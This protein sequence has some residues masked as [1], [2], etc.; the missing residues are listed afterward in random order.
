[1]TF[2]EYFDIFMFLFTFFFHLI[3]CK[4]HVDIDCTSDSNINYEDFI[5]EFRNENNF[6]SHLS[7]SNEG[8]EN[9]E[10]SKNE[11]DKILSTNQDSNESL[12]IEID[13][14]ISSPSTSNILDQSSKPSLSSTHNE[15][16]SSNP[17]LPFN[18]SSSESKDENLLFTEGQFYSKFNTPSPTDNQDCNSNFDN[19]SPIANQDSNSNYD[20]NNDTASQDSNSNSVN[21]EELKDHNLKLQSKLNE[22]H[23]HQQ[24]ADKLSKEMNNM[25]SKSNDD[26]SQ[27]VYQTKENVIQ[28]TE[29]TERAILNNL[30]VAK[31]LEGHENCPDCCDTHLEGFNNL[32]KELKNE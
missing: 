28:S 32:S 31:E 13:S 15:I 23:K 2:S 9:G 24:E 29:M 7:L 1:M 6:N 4:Y 19:T 10:D 11:V 3:A 26:L 30:K 14:P 17:E 12:P 21:R 16:T 27:K 8:N 25:V 22:T 18:T 20:N 5:K